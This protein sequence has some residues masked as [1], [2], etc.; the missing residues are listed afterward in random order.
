M[1][2]MKLVLA[3]VAASFLSTG[4]QAAVSYDFAPIGTAPKEGTTITFD[5]DLPKGVRVVGGLIQSASNSYG[6]NPTGSSNYLTS[7]SSAGTGSASIFSDV[8]YKTISFDWGSIDSYNT[9]ALLDAVGNA[10]FTLS[11]AK[12]PV[13]NGVAGTRISLTSD[14]QAIYGL[15]IYSGSPAFEVDNVTLSSAVP[16]PAT[17]G[18]M[19]LGF[20]AVGAS[21]RR[22]SSRGTAVAA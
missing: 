18:L 8:G 9:F 3:A 14:S 6:A 19:I 2:K 1:T 7:N 17:W 13:A 21:L 11:G 5:T 12:A 16:E 20:G 15:R 22:R 4:A 10:F